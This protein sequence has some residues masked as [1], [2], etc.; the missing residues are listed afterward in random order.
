MNN[1]ELSG[2]YCIENNINNKVYI[3]S[4]INLKRRLGKHFSELKHNKHGNIKLQRFYNKYRNFVILTYKILEYCEPINLIKREQYHLNLHNIED[5]FN[6]NIIANSRLGVKSSE[7]T[8][9]KIRSALLGKSP[10]Q[11]TKDKIRITLTGTKLSKER[12]KMKCKKINQ[13]NLKGEFVKTWNSIKEISIFYAIERNRITYCLK[14]LH[15]S[16]INF[17]W[18]YYTSN[19]SNIE[20]LNPLNKR[21]VGLIE[22]DIVIKEYDSIQEAAQDLKLCSSKIGAVCRGYRKTTGGYKFT[23]L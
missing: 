10:S 1:L 18:R 17:Y 7:N 5:L 12:I 4:A 8:K 2:I 15:L 20:V 13:Y 23:Y 11:T 21:R 19:I 3:G 6:I 9:Q 16:F 14:H 22:N